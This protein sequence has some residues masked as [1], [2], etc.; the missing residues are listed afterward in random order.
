VRKICFDHK[1]L[2]VGTFIPELETTLGT[3][4]L[5]PTRLYPKM[6]LPLLT[7]IKGM[8]HVTGG[9]FYDNIPRIL[10]KGIA[11][12]IAP[13]NWMIPP[14]FTL[15]QQWGN[16]ADAEMFRTF[17]M[18]IGLILVA[19]ADQA[20]SLIEEFRAGGEDAREIG[21]VVADGIA[22]TPGGVHIEGIE[23]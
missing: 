21:S 12:R 1:K 23:R 16:V 4:L 14:I 17:N 10:P 18:G 13:K 7:G 5:K 20:R 22:A 19:S 15:L 2:T 6:V 8:V 9:G 11:V 3:E